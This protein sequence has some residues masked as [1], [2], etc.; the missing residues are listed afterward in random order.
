MAVDQNPLE[1]RVEEI[2]GV[3]TRIVYRSD[4]TGYTVCS[5][6]PAA[7]QPAIRPP[8][9]VEPEKHASD[10]EITVVGTCAALWVG[11]SL[12]ATGN[13]VQHRKH[14]L[15]FQAENLTCMAPLSS[16]GIR[17]YLAG[18]NIQGIGVVIADRIVDRFGD[19]TLRIIDKE[20]KRLLEVPGIGKKTWERIRQSWDSQKAVRDIMIFLRSHGVGA[21]QAAR[22]HRQYGSDA[23][24]LIMANP[25]RLCREVWGIGFKSADKIAISLGIPRDS[26]IRARAGILY[27]LETMTDEGHCF[28]P[29]EVLVEAGQSLLDIPSDT[30]NVAI[31]HEL[32]AN[33]L[34]EE[35]GNIYLSALHN[36]EVQMA[37]KL[38]DLLNTPQGFDPIDVGKAV[39]WAE[40]RMGIQFADAQVTAI[41][42]ALSQKMCIITGG[43]GVGKTTIIRALVDVFRARK[44]IT[45]LAAPTG[46]AAKR[47]A[48]ATGGEA[49]TIHRLLK[50]MPVTRQFDH[51]PDNLLKGDVFILDEVSMVDTLLMHSF[52]QALDSKSHL[53]LVGDSDQLPSVGP[54]NVLHDLIGSGAIPSARLD[55][56][57]RQSQQSMIVQNA[58]RINRGE[59]IE[60]SDNGA[61]SD[62]YFIRTEEPDEVVRIMLELISSRIPGKFKFNPRTQVQVLTPMRRNQLGADNLNTLLQETLNPEGIALNRFGRLYRSGDRVMQIRNN[63]DKDI[64][65]GDIG[66][67]NSIDLEEQHLTVDF[68]GRAVG[69]DASELDELVLAYA[70][71]IHKSQGSEYP[72]V[73]ILMATQ[74]YKLLQRNLLYTALTRGRKL[75]CLVGSSK[76]VHIAIRNNNTTLR[77]T[78]LARRLHAPLA[79]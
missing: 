23:V 14:G 9:L 20:S 31:Q 71:S 39:P 62:F 25:Y 48:E 33:T 55:V 57:F 44:L 28:C 35:A 50:F 79:N 68:D 5:V 56:I 37:K 64:F 67:V 46:R 8:S 36:A 54:G 38:R 22:I 15:Q 52:L 3:V 47:L 60:Q 66:I 2:S 11:E 59:S 6:K 21:A 29:W 1:D 32:R 17:M 41:R 72:A 13:W 77:R 51:G 26:E 45:H 12:K 18:S 74:H 16:E 75:V 42:S 30:L 61:D 70:C 24:A 19:D 76:A 4:D 10:R 53:I 40:Q 78:S 69:Y 49:K 7:S 43:P 58:H 65:N 63:Y 34:V 73:I 27:V